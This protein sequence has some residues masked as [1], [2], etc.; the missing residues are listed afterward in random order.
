MSH[1]QNETWL[2]FSGSS[3][4]SFQMEGFRLPRPFCSLWYPGSSL[5]DLRDL[6]SSSSSYPASHSHCVLH[7]TPISWEIL[8]SLSKYGH[9]VGVYAFLHCSEHFP[10]GNYLWLGVSIKITP[11]RSGEMAQRLR[12]LTALPKVPSSNPSN[13]MVAY[14]HLQ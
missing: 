12:A 8:I 6:C 10:W 11:F 3:A 7:C 4:P 13:H 14:N 5:S 1:K 9:V 2:C